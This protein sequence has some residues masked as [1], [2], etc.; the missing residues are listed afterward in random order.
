[1]RPFLS[2]RGFFNRLWTRL[3]RQKINRFCFGIGLM[4]AFALSRLQTLRRRVFLNMPC[5]FFLELKFADHM[6]N[7]PTIFC[8]DVEPDEREIKRGVA[9]DWKGFEETF[10]FLSNLRPLLE[11][12]T[13]APVRFSWFFRMDPQIEQTYG[14]SWWVAKRYPEIIEKLELAGDEIGLHTH[15][16]RWD[17]GLNQWITDNG[18]QKWINQC[19][20]TSFEAYQS[21]FGRPC[22]AF[23]FGDHWMSNETI[24]LLESLGVKFE[25]TVEPGRK[26]SPGLMPGEVYTGSLPDYSTVPNWPYKPSRLDF[27]KDSYKRDR[28]LWVVPMSTDKAVGRFVGVKRA[29]KALGIDLYEADQLNLSHDRSQF[30]AMMKSLLDVRMNS[31]LAPAIKSDAVLYPPAK[32]HLDQN[33]RFIL[34]HPSVNRFKFVGPAEAIELLT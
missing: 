23:R 1:M 30:S 27:R 28:D 3:L 10:K 7:I 34:S 20:H 9:K 19:I 26:R 11:E 14:L 6:R 2:D 16:W 32:A 24:D 8:I 4:R 29:A 31:Y 21:A 25:M 22:L 12:A 33:V 17:S 13:G 15:A 18:N 5:G